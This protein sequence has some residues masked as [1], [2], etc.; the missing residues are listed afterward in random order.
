MS[1]LAVSTDNE[2]ARIS[3]IIT[4]VLYYDYYWFRH[5]SW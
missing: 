5:Q 2:P 1:T 4:M 3:A